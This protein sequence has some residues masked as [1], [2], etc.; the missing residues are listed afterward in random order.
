MKLI[1]FLGAGVS[2]P[3]GLPKVD[4][5]TDSIFSKAYH[6]VSYNQFSPGPQPDPP[7]QAED[8]TTRIRQLLQL[9][10]EHD[11]RDISAPAIH[12]Q[13][14]AAP[15]LSFAAITRRTKIY[16]ISANR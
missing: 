15:E 7:L 16:S 10:R 8:V 5:L 2:V 4:E 11:E 13:I 3:S 12:R 1:L 9:L 6:Q 14:N